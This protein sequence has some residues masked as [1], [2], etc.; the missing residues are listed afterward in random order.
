MSVSFRYAWVRQSLPEDIYFSTAIDTTRRRGP[1]STTNWRSNYWR[2]ALTIGI[3]H[4]NWKCSRWWGGDRGCRRR[5]EHPHLGKSNSDDLLTNKFIYSNSICVF[6][7]SYETSFS[8]CISGVYL[9]KGPNHN[10]MNRNVFCS[11]RGRWK[12]V[13]NSA[14]LSSWPFG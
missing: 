12:T 4:Q 3:Q 1:N 10:A 2:K 7:L 6:L 5:K 14:V 8:G 11:N 13:D 9:C